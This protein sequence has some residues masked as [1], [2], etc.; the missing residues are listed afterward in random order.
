MA[1]EKEKVYVTQGGEGGGMGML[2][3]VL[4]VVLIGIG[5]LFAAG[6]LR[7]DK[8]A[9]DVNVDLPKVDAPKSDK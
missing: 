4:I 7:E 6:A 1:E 2:A 9:I 5:F 3:G 8:A